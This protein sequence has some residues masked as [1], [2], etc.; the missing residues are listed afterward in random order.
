MNAIFYRA[1]ALCPCIQIIFGNPS[2]PPQHG[3]SAPKSAS[4]YNIFP[5]GQR[6]FLY[7][8]KIPLPAER[9]KCGPVFLRRDP[10]PGPCPRVGWA[11]YG[12]PRRPGLSSIPAGSRARSKP[13]EPAFYR[14]HIHQA[15][16]IVEVND[17]L[18]CIQ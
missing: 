16:R 9:G 8:F 3:V 5:F 6:N 1:H 17:P 11:N 7:L 15:G 13:A 14:R 12:R 4:C 18:F 2:R 10:A